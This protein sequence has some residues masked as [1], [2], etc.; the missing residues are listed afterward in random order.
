MKNFIG[1]KESYTSA[2]I[3]LFG[4]PFDATSSFRAGSRFGPD[5]IRLVSDEIETYSPYQDRDLEDINFMDA[6]NLEIS[7]G[8]IG[9]AMDV[10]HDFSAKLIK[11]NK[12]PF[13]LGGEHLITYPIIKALRKKYREITLIHLDAHTDLREG[14]MGFQLSHA[15]VIRLIWDL[16]N[17]SL[18]QVGIR[19]GTREEFR[20][21]KKNQT[22]Y[23]LNQLEKINEKIRNK[24]VYITLDVDVFDPSVLPGTGTPEAGGMTFVP[25]MEFLLGLRDFN[26]IGL[27]VVELNPEVDRSQNSSIFAS[28]LVRELLL[29]VYS[30]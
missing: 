1:A 7:P 15:S 25:F 4:V 29:K 9:S 27:D 14:Y 12:I 17:I 3:V 23:S 5:F 11:D 2:K 6:G 18:V 28:Q 13:A 20:F 22:L 19:S 26:L 8:D 24:N 10:I 30:K 16:K 21:M